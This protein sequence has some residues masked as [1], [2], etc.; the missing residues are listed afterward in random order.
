MLPKSAREKGKRLERWIANQLK[1]IDKYT[2]RRADSG[3]GRLRKE[4]VFTTLPFFI[5]AKNQSK[6]NLTNW[7]KQTLEGCPKDKLPVLVYKQN[8][9][10]DPYIM[11]YLGDLL[12]YLSG[13]KV[14][15]KYK[16]IMFFSEWFSIIKERYENIQNR[17]V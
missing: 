9:Q 6:L 16:V 11:M 1:K 12:Y 2:Y 5:E 8:Y 15:L 13:K 17:N 10:R 7:W 14:D 3:S 4:D